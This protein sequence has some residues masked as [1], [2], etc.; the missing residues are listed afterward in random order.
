MLQNARQI[1]NIVKETSAELDL[2][3]DAR[4]GCEQLEPDEVLSC[5][6]SQVSMISKAG[7][8]PYTVDTL[9]SLTK[10]D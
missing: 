4:P 3:S 10:V 6:W 7:S 5:M 8:Y 1:R 2:E 9:R